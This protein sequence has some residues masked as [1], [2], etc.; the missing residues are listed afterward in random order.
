MKNFVHLHTHT[1][2]SLLDGACK[3]PELMEQVKKKGMESIAMTDHGV[4]YGTIAFYKAAKAAGLHPVIGCEVYVAPRSRWDKVAGLDDKPFHLI[5]LAENQRGYQN[6]IKLVSRSWLEGF[7]YKPRVDKALLREFSEGLIAL[8][9][10][11]AGEIP[12]LISQGK[13][14]DARQSAEEYAE[15]FGRNN[16][17]LELQDHGLA[18]QM[19]V[20][21]GLIEIHQQT[22]L[23]IVATNDVHYLTREDAFVQ[24]VLMCI[25]MGKTLADTQRMQ[26]ATDAFYLKDAQEMALLFGDHPEALSNTVDIAQRCQVDFT[27]D[28]NHL[29]PF[30]L[31]EGESSEAEYLRKQCLEGLERRYPGIDHTSPESALPLK[32]LEY[33]LSMIEGMGFSGYFLIVWD[34]IQFAR[35]QGIYV[36]PGRGSAA[37]SIVAYCLGITNIDPLKYDLLFER[38]LNPER[39]SMPDIDID[40]CYIRRSEVIEYVSQRYGQDRV[41]QI[42]TFG[43]MAAKAAIRDAGRAMGVPLPLVD[44]VA[45]LIPAELNITLERALYLSKELEKLTTEDEQVKEL[46]RVARALEGMPR[47]SG[48]HAAGLVIAGQPLESMLPLQRSS[49]GLPCTQ[50]EKDTVE[51]IGLLKMD[52][53]GLRT[54]TVIGNAV[55]LIERSQGIQVDID[56]L[57]L[58]DQATF[59]LL[60]KGDTIGVFQLESDGLRQILRELKPDRF[61]DIIA[62]VAL[63]RPGPLGSGMV[64][65][66]IKRRHGEIEQNYLH[67]L[68][69]PILETTYGVILYQEQVMRIA[70]DMGG[71]SLGQADQLRRAMGKKKPEVL[72]AYQESFVNGALNKGVPRETAIKVFEL[73]AYFSGYGFNK[74]HSA[75]YALVAYQTAWL[76]AHY[77]V[78]F[79]AAL[80]S[81]VMETKDKV[82]FYIEACKQMKIQILAPDVNES[83]EGFSVAKGAIRFG[84][85]AIKQVGAPAIEAIIRERQANGPFESLEVFCRR[86]D[87]THINR[88]ALENLIWA[89]AFASVKGNRAQLL[90]V[91]PQAIDQAMAWHKNAN[92]SQIS[93]FDVNPEIKIEG[94]QIRLPDLEEVYPEEILNMEKEVLGLYLSGH[95]LSPFQKILENKTS[96]RIEAL[97]EVTEEKQVILGGMIT[98]LRKTVTKRG[99]LMAHFRLED[100]TGSV[101]VLVFPKLFTKLA[102]ALMPDQVVLVRGTY[103]GQED[104][105]KIFVDDLQPLKIQET[106]QSISQQL[107]INLGSSIV[108]KDPGIL[109]YLKQMLLANHGHVPVF[110][111]HPEEKKVIE[112][113]QE[114]T[115]QPTEALLAALRARLGQRN[116]ILK[117]N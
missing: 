8:S 104:Q 74:S 44:K 30:P 45:K 50:F 96:H 16:F 105:P 4:M 18:E 69:E 87:L 31:P 32:R 46:M 58:D 98:A 54:L 92:S 76:K 20:N 71:L 40:V 21:Q 75:A 84:L 38:F 23:G 80:L 35:N 15:I 72:A 12:V 101:D 48:V 106:N 1:C 67:P 68:L 90:A 47:H 52:L 99:Q 70:G 9:A 3:I 56:H 49:E 78:E 115:T 88:R 95:P 79:M 114:Y 116:V 62:L 5:L 89:G 24:D 110:L 34:F 19:S 59:S 61:D 82:P 85:A 65:D 42:V 22:G 112:M 25:Q 41:C 43:T 11:L 102:A 10:C 39:I 100:L 37:G 28:Q 81:S 29:P 2:F 63:Y 33:E 6:L 57:S 117:G 26:F 97:A 51:S 111:Y 27:F 13:F 73:M 64:E 14:E 66:Y 53:L 94:D 83:T 108:E 107:W 86:V 55:S 36:G 93:L 17:F 113:S 60:S 77:P 109:E 7:Y 103:Q 91:L